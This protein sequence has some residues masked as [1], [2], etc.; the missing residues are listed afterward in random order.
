MLSISTQICISIAFALTGIFSMPTGAYAPARPYP[1]GLIPSAAG[2][3]PC[4][5]G[6]SPVASK[7]TSNPPA[8]VL[9]FMKR[10]DDKYGTGKCCVM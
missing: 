8:A 7:L 4:T 6:S 1:Y 2:P 5:W 3:Y 10:P 9:V